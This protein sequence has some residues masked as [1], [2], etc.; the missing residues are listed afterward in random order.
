MI[1]QT[2]GI[3]LRAFDFRETSRIATFFTR[4][5][6]KVTG[7]LKGIRKDPR[8]FGSAV[9]RFS[10]NDLV[11]YPSRNSDLHLVSHCDLRDYFPAV[12]VEVRKVLAASYAVDLVQ[13]ITPVEQAQPRVYHLLLRFLKDLGERVDVDRLVPIFQIKIL[14]ASGFHPHLE[15]CLHC[16]RE[17]RGRPRFSPRGGGLVC[18]GC[19]VPDPEAVAVAPPVIAALRHIARNDWT[20]AGRLTLHDGVRRP[21]QAI[22]NRFLVFHLGRRLRSARYLS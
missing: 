17:I 15:N 18:P 9:D 19:P 10:L 22:V 5:H 11:Y 16:G 3:V 7:I 14:S 8:K 6:G 20:Y 12:R 21:L 13:A 4:D 2:P 1:R